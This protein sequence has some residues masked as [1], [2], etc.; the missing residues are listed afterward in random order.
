MF[1][2][3]PAV[4]ILAMEIYC[5]GFERWEFNCVD[6]ECK[7]V[8]TGPEIV[9]IELKTVN[10]PGKIVDMLAM[11]KRRL[12]Q[13]RVIQKTNNKGD[14]EVYFR[15]GYTLHKLFGFFFE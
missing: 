7:T 8:D 2:Y 9:N 5:I 1:Y 14:S 4:E 12:G 3:M 11:K 13:K 6:I 15:S 10:I